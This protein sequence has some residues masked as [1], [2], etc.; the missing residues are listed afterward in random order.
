MMNDL[1]KKNVPNPLVQKSKSSVSSDFS[2]P[3]VDKRGTYDRSQNSQQ[4]RKLGADE[5]ELMEEVDHSKLKGSTLGHEDQVKSV[6]HDWNRLGGDPYNSEGLIKTEVPEYVHPAL[7]SKIVA[8]RKID[9]SLVT[10]YGHTKKK[11]SGLLASLL[12]ML[13]LTEK[14]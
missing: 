12:S 13:G 11:K 7:V 10:K 1:P 9:H 6:D 8:N 3:K 14:K 4:F 2:W 5:L